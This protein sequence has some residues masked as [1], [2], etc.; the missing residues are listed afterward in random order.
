[1]VLIDIFF[2]QAP[3]LPCGHPLPHW[4]S[5][6]RGAAQLPAVYKIDVIPE[7]CNRGSPAYLA[8]YK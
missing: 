4:A 2:E 5:E 8:V 3:H 6:R 7:I 1:M